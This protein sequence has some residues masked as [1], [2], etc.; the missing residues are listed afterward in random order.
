MELWQKLQIAFFFWPVLLL[1]LGFFTGRM[2][3]KRHLTRIEKAEQELSHIKLW[4]SGQFPKELN[5]AGT[6]HN[7]LVNGNVTLSLDVFR[8]FLNMVS[9]IFG[10]N[11]KS[12]EHLCERGR[13]EAVIRMKR[14]AQHFGADQI[15]DVRF[16]GYSVLGKGGRMSGLEFLAYGTAV[17]TQNGGY[18]EPINV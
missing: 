14:K 6:G 4:T 8:Q 17:K 2:I 15:L 11:L 10:K 12:A 16:A 9:N 3:S 5:V 18:G 7:A 1:V 13:R